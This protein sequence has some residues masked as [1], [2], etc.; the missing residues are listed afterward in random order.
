VIAIIAILIGLLIPAVQKVRDAA[1]KTA[2]RN[3]LHQLGL[4]MHNYHDANG[5]F[6]PGNGIPSGQ[7][8][9]PGS[10]PGFTGIWSDQRFS[11]LPWGTF[12]WAAFILPY[13]EG[14]NTY[15]IINFNYP[16]YTSA[17]E[18]Y[19]KD[20][21]SGRSN[22]LTLNGVVQ[23]GAGTNGF[24]DLANKQA[25]I[26]MPKVFVCPAALRARPENEQ[27]DYGINGGIQKSGCCV[28][29]NTNDN[30]GIAALGSNVKIT[31]IADG[32]SCTFMILELANNSEHGRIDP[33]YGAN[34]FFFVNE[35][36]QGYVQ[37][38]TN[39][40]LSGVTPPNDASYNTHGPESDHEGV[41]VGKG[42]ADEVGPV[43]GAGGSGVFAV[44]CDG[45][46]VWVP[47]SVNTTV[48]LGCF[49]R[50]GGEIAATD[51]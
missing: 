51:F 31:D 47:N 41:Y 2:C 30:E 19:G 13:V 11:G 35:A 50:A 46:V 34:P 5:T 22:G 38:S 26:S 27:K 4:A 32:T 18:E 24:G 36:G 45:H 3:N 49:T 37:G 6:P 1:L 48:Y 12:G 44:F 39:G 21:T 17:F 14:G 40:A 42:N 28:E 7:T 20:P 15:A 25:A 33:G 10:N 43:G 16:A 8:A 23:S 29:R 9:K